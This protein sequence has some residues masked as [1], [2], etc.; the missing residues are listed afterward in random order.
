MI[1]CFAAVRGVLFCRRFLYLGK[2]STVLAPHLLAV[3]KGVEFGSGC[4]I[5]CLSVGGI[6]IGRSS[7]IGDY[8]IIRVSGSLKDLGDSIKIGKNVGIGDFA[9][10]G[11]AGGVTIG[12]D[13]IFGSYISIHPEN[14]VFEDTTINIREQKVTRKGVSIGRNCWVGAKATFLD[15]SAIGDGCVVAA[16]SVVTKVF[17]DNLVIGGVPAR[18]LKVRE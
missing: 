14:H 3:D 15:G 18:I 1:K 2:G 4:L 9:H 7:K 16:G 10:I 13:S 8:C 6:K 12:D 17:Q 5:D 11:G